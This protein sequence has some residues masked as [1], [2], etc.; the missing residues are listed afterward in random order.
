L[1]LYLA[2]KRSGLI[3]RQ[4]GEASG[5]TQ[6]KTVGKVVHR[7]KRSLAIEVSRRRAAR[8]CIRQV[9]LGEHDPTARFQAEKFC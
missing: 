6:Y 9:S 5:I 8:D 7:F 4:I 3:L 1:V 2:R